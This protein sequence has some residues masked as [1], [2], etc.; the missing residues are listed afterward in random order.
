[1]WSAQPYIS[2]LSLCRQTAPSSEASGEKWCSLNRY[3]PLALCDKISKT[4]VCFRSCLLSGHSKEALTSSFHLRSYQVRKP[5]LSD[6]PRGEP[7]LVFGELVLDLNMH[8]P[9]EF[10]LFVIL[11]WPGAGFFIRT[12]LDWHT[13]FERSFSIISVTSI[14]L[15]FLQPLSDHVPSSS[16]MHSFALAPPSLIDSIYCCCLQLL[17]FWSLSPKI[18]MPCPS[19]LFFFF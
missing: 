12:L 6:H 16:A 13:R 18:G 17:F 11:G 9:L 1:M 7:S 4:G 3:F 14:A 15:V 2:E 5:L 10:W 8:F 19:F